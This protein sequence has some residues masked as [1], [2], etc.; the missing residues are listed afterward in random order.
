MLKIIPKRKMFTIVQTQDKWTCLAKDGRQLYPLKK[1][2]FGNGHTASAYSIN[3]G[4]Y[5]F[6]E[7]EYAF[8]EIEE[9]G[10]AGFGIVDKNGSI[11]TKYLYEDI[12]KF[13]EGLAPAKRSGKWGFINL[14]GDECIAPQYYSVDAFERGISIVQIYVN[15]S[16]HDKIYTGAIA[17]NGNIVIPLKNEY[18]F[19]YGNFLLG[20]N[21]YNYAGKKI[22]SDILY[23]ETIKW[24]EH[25]IRVA[26][27]VG[28]ERYNQYTNRSEWI[29]DTNGREIVPRGKFEIIGYLS[30]GLAITEKHHKIRGEWEEVHD[31]LDTNGNVVSVG[32]HYIDDFHG[33]LAPVTKWDN[34]K[35]VETKFA[36]IDKRFKLVTDF[37]FDQP[38]H[39]DYG[40]NCW[41]CT[42]TGGESGCV[43]SDGSLDSNLVAALK[44]HTWDTK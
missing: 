18:F 21:L 4:L 2:Y 42:I 44:G 34:E 38:P 43:R 36:F 31:I 5:L 39:F 17:A 26:G 23:D 1:K 20:P 14:K 41:I 11:V 37:D 40:K 3:E 22:Y 6:G 27:Y 33:G 29:I 15:D 24:G 28:Q 32:W 35:K 25:Y 10:D 30:E 8:V 7:E 16:P 12:G 13:S 9:R 19:R